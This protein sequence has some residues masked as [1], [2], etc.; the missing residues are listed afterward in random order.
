MAEKFN[1]KLARFQYSPLLHKDFSENFF[2]DFGF[3]EDIVYP[4]WYIFKAKHSLIIDLKKN[5]DDLYS[6]VRKSNKPHINKTR[7][8]TKCYI[9][10]SSDFDQSL[11][12]RYVDLYFSVKGEKRSL[13][14][15]N[16]D[17]KAIK[18]GLEVL[19]LCEYNNSLVGAIALHTFSRKARYNS[20]VQDSKINRKVY[21]IHFLLWQAI[22]YL[23][24]QG[25]KRFEI[26]EQ[27]SDE[28]ANKISDKE[29]NLF[30][31]KSG[32]GGNLVPWVKIEKK[33]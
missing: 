16:Q 25:F 12:D 4:D 18:L 23:K 17:A 31:F 1:C 20:S 3:V 19:M 21:P 26:G 27:I 8:E 28:D 24:N 11:F 30:H 14:A 6:A 7:R 32:W 5:V 29:K 13:L 15:F 9:L 10:D 2:K 33:Y 22:L